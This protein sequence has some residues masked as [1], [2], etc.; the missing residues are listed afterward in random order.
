MHEKIFRRAIE[1][2][3]ADDVLSS[4]DAN[5]A[6]L[7]QRAAG[8]KVWTTPNILTLTQLATVYN[9]LEGKPGDTIRVPTANATTVADNLAVDVPATDD[10]SADLI[11]TMAASRAF[12]L[13]HPMLFDLMYSRRFGDFSPELQASLWHSKREQIHQFTWQRGSSLRELFSTPE[14]WLDAGLAN[15]L[16]LPAP[17]GQGF[18]KVTLKATERAV[19]LVL[20]I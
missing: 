13:E 6:A 12:A 5:H 9:E 8:R 1:E 17:A 14:L 10:A 11:D 2:R 19:L 15:L 18:Q 16:G 20:L 3:T 4:G 7:E